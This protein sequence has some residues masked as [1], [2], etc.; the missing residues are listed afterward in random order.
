MVRKNV[1]KWLEKMLTNGYVNKRLEKML[2]NGRLKTNWVLCAKAIIS[3]LV[4]LFYFF[5]LKGFYQMPVIFYLWA[6]K[7]NSLHNFQNKT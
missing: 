7:S 2:I 1:I 3:D 4:N 5:P 6:Q